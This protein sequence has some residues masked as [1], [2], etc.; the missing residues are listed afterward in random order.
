MSAEFLAET[1]RLYDMIK[2][3]KEERAQLIQAR[4]MRQK[5][6]HV[7]SMESTG[8]CRGGVVASRSRAEPNIII[9]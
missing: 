2:R 9:N 4:K 7:K 1:E 6:E 5:Q 3:Q 8:Y